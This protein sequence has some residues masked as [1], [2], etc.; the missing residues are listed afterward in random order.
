MRFIAQSVLEGLR[1]LGHDPQLGH[2][3][4]VTLRLA[5]ES[6]AIAVVIGLPI[7]C[8]LGL[9]RSRTSRGAM[10]AAT[11]G[12]GLPPVTVGVYARLLLTEPGLQPPWGGTWLNS[13]NGMVLCQTIIALP[14]VTALA[15]VAVRALPDAILDQA[16]AFGAS[17]PRLAVLA[18]REAKLGITTAVIVALASAIGEVGAIALIIASAGPNETLATQVIQDNYASNRAAEME[19]VL[20]LLAMM[21]VLGAVLVIARQSGARARRRD[22]RAGASVAIGATS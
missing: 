15:A 19:H 9:G 14:I 21:A 6:T 11:A 5:L 16:R 10:I 13:L 22:A 4:V 8:A 20:V 12:L 18:V 1:T 7:A 2:L 17:G 3:I